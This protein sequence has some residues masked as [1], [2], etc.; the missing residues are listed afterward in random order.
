MTRR[1]RNEAFEIDSPEV[2]FPD[3]GSVLWEWFW[4]IRSSQSSG[5]NGVMRVSNGELVDWIQIT[6]NVLR[7][8]E[9]SILRTMDVRYCVEIDREAEAIRD[10]E[11]S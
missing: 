4:D 2:E 10:R 3:E 6:G 7:R 5:F 8:E 11:N 1:E 9:V